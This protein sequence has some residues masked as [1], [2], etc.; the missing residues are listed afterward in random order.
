MAKEEVFLLQ[1][2]ANMFF[3]QRNS[4]AGICGV[5]VQYHFWG[6][7]SL[8]LLSFVFCSCLVGGSRGRLN[9]TAEDN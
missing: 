1:T 5:E 6:R 4:S 9:A 8:L 2:S 3:A 7:F